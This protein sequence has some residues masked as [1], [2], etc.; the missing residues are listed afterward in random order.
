MELRF[1]NTANGVPAIVYVEALCAGAGVPIESVEREGLNRRYGDS[2]YDS[3][4]RSCHVYMRRIAAFHGIECEL[5]AR[6]SASCTSNLHHASR[7]NGTMT[8][9]EIN[10]H[11]VSMFEVVQC[12]PA[13]SVTV[14]GAI[15]N[16][17]ISRFPRA[18]MP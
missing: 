7:A 12:L 16:L 14:G 10:A 2:Y 3:E 8:S 4:P 11:V 18:Q 17:I 15:G 6:I 9:N 5:S 1:S 13:A